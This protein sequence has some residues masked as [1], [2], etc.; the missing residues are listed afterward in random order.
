MSE[1][2]LGHLLTGGF[3]I[4]WKSDLDVLKGGMMFFAKLEP[5][6]VFTKVAF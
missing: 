5:G 1:H 4:L 6:R 2:M 3:R